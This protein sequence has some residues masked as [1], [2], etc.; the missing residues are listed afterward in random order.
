MDRHDIDASRATS[1][2]IFFGSAA[3]TSEAAHQAPPIPTLVYRIDDL[4]R[5]IGLSKWTVYDLIK[6]GDFPQ[7]IQLTSKAVGWRAS[8]IQRWVDERKSAPH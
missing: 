1:E 7:P 5:V 3:G 6:K 4:R 2:S 8:D